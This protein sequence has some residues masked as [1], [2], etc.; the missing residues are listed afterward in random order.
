MKNLKSTIKVESLKL[1]LSHDV[2]KGTK[3]IESG[4]SFLLL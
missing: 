3:V 1:S 2:T 4:R